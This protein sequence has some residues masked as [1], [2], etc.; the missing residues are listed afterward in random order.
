MTERLDI[1]IA[2]PSYSGYPKAEHSVSVEMLMQLP[3]DPPI[4]WR[5]EVLSNCPCLPRVR[6]ALIAKAFAR[7]SCSLTRISTSTP[8]TCCV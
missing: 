8:A 2:V 1:M 6:N 5:H 3:T 7:I 4:V